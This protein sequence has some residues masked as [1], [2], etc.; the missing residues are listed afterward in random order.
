MPGFRAFLPAPPGFHD[1]ENRFAK[2]KG[3]RDDGGSGAGTSARSRV[4]P[5]SGL[6]QPLPPTAEETTAD[7]EEARAQGRSKKKHSAPLPEEVEEEPELDLD[8]NPF[9][10]KKSSKPAKPP[11]PPKKW[12]DDDDV[13]PISSDMSVSSIG[14][15]WRMWLLDRT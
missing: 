10:K 5:R 15:E 13:S 8:D 7:M 12:E 2:R 4:D 11:P 9:A 3:K 6:R 1:E 14:G